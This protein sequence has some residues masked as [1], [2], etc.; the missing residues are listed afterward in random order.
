MIDDSVGSRSIAQ[1]RC[2]VVGSLSERLKE[3]VYGV[4]GLEQ[5][6]SP[7]EASTF[8]SLKAITCTVYAREDI[9]KPI[10]NYASSA[11]A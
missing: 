2:E 7:P 3:F 10:I 9:Q 8:N 4:H 6:L 5:S 1:I 11:I